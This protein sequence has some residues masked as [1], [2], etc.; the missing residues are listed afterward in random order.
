MC[1]CSQRML[2]KLQL[3]NNARQYCVGH[4]GYGVYGKLQPGTWDQLSPGPAAGPLNA[5]RNTVLEN[6]EAT[7]LT[8]QDPK[9]H[10][11]QAITV[12]YSSLHPSLAAAATG[13]ES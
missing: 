10:Q 2:T 9:E 13:G 5:K 4:P 8:G 3:S 11:P 7:D 1:F 12:L 6:I